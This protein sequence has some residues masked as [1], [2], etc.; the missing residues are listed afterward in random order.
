MD[1]N[2][3]DLD[4]DGL[5]DLVVEAHGWNGTGFVSIVYSKTNFGDNHFP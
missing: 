3:G 4:G 1:I 5:T 2:I